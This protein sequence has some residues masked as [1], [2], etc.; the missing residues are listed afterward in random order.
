M[1]SLDRFSLDDKVILVT[2][3]TSRYGRH[4][5]RDIAEAG[6]T[7]IT[8]SRDE[9]AARRIADEQQSRGYRVVP[10]RLD[11]GD[12]DSIE[13][14][15]DRLEQEYET[16]DGLVNNAV[17]RPMSNLDDEISAWR[18]S[19]EENATGLFSLTRRIAKQMAAGSG[20]SIVNVSSIQGM[21]GPDQTLYAGTN[22][23]DGGELAPPPDYYFHKGGLINLT[24]YFA[25]V[26]GP[27]RVRVNAV[28]PGGIKDDDQHP[29]F[30]QRY[31][32]RTA[33]GRLAS[34]EEVSSVILFLLSDG[35]SYVTGVNI[36]VDGGY[37]AK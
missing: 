1:L 11:L 34:G 36:P 16:I 25:L 30:V 32:N 9:E 14:L 15:S 35:A 19:M 31:E 7:V 10:A 8:T 5:V 33:L 22:M 27:A 29:L 18:Q 28:S 37:S 13:K 26:F 12:R 24:R 2:A 23:Y 3:G 17:S 20:G 6:A 21:H 4:I